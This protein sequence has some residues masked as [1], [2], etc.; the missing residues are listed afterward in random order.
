MQYKYYIIIIIKMQI[1]I[2]DIILG[3]LTSELINSIDD[4]NEKDNMYININITEQDLKDFNERIINPSNINSIIKLCDFL[5]IN[6]NEMIQLIIYNIKPTN[7]KYVLNNINKSNCKDLLFI[8]NITIDY[9][10]EYDLIEW[11]KFKFN[12]CNT[13]KLCENCVKKGAIKCL[14]YAYENGC[15][16]DKN[17]CEYAARFGQLECLKYVHENGCPWNEITCYCAALNGKIE[18][19]KYLH[20]NKCPWD[21]QTCEYA[22][23]YGRLECLKYAVI[24]GCHWDKMTCNYATANGQLECLKYAHENGCLWDENTCLFAA[25]HGEFECLKYLHENGCPWNETV[26][27]YAM[28]KGNIECLNYLYKNGCPR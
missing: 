14:K 3:N 21:K 8:E 11:L 9:I 17:L 5:M 7:E 12:K 24:N 16:F 28:K 4:D 2:N 27:Y 19:L 10:L 23:T 18:C 20:E 1:N 26:Y 15:F 25:Q 6:Y 13:E 22:V